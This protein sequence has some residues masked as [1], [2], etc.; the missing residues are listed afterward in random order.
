MKLAGHGAFEAKASGEHSQREPVG[1]HSI[2]RQRQGAVRF[3]DDGPGPLEWAQ[4]RG[5]RPRLLPAC[6]V[7]RRH[8]AWGSRS[9]VPWSEVRAV[10]PTIPSVALRSNL[11]DRGRMPR[12]L[13]STSTEKP[14][15][16]P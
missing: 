10:H 16:R 6:E 4:C 12:P 9:G 15:M 8:S 7:W 11:P 3:D 14:V 1:P 13:T 5:Q 2:L